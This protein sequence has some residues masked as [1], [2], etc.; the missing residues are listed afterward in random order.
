MKNGKCIADL[1]MIYKNDNIINSTTDF[2][3]EGWFH[4]IYLWNNIFIIPIYVFQ[5]TDRNFENKLYLTVKSILDPLSHIFN[6]I[7]LKTK[8]SYF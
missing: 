7:L 2:E 4:A 1:I 8:I 5:S 6:L 3:L